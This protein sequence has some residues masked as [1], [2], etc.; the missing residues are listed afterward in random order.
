MDASLTTLVLGASENPERYSHMAIVQLRQENYPVYAV[1]SRPG[2][3]L[4]VPI[5]TQLSP[6]WT[7]DTVTL[8]L[9][10]TLQQAYYQTILSLRP[11]RI[12][13]NPGT[14]NP[15]F[16]A[17]ARAAGIITQDACTL[18]LLRTGQYHR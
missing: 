2:Q 3:V 8:Y 4:D 7:I 14:E 15:D 12:I 10:N 11:R 17:M 9:N 18:V 5:E 16:S 1:G 13:F 6:T